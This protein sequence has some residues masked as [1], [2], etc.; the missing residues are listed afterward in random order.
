VIEVGVIHRSREGLGTAEVE[1]IP[2]V[3]ETIVHHGA[4]LKVVRVVHEAKNKWHE[5][6]VHLYVKGSTKRMDWDDR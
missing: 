4:N 2:R 6:R 3:G 1:A 5:A